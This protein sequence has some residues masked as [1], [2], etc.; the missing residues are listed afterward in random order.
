MSFYYTRIVH[1]QDTDAAGVVYFVN[2]L[3][4]CHEAYEASL[5]AFDIN[6]KVFFSNIK[7]AMYSLFTGILNLILLKLSLL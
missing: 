4:M 5:V 6:L 2:V 7:K 1:L 3:A